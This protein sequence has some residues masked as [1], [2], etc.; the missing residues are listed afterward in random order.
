MKFLLYCPEE[1]QL[2]MMRHLRKVN[3]DHLSVGWYQSSQLGNF[4]SKSLVES[5]F[6]YQTSIEESVVIVYGK[7]SNVISTIYINIP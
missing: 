5:Q 6:S 1:Y 2:D 4:V 7:S 3:V